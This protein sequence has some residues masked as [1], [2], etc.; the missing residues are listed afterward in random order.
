LHVD[1]AGNPN[2]VFVQRCKDGIVERTDCSRTASTCNPSGP[3]GA[4]CRGN[5][6]ACTA[7]SL[8]NDTL[9]CDGNTLVTCA[10]GQEAK[11][12]CGSILLSCF[13]NPNGT[14]FGCFA[15]NACAPDQFL[16][17]CAGTKLTFCNKGK[18]DTIDCA[19][20]G[21]KSCDPGQGGRCV[22]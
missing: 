4:H 2:G 8:T 17:T 19:S 6:Q 22:P 1:A 18:V 21:F 12:D 14:G 11:F 3:L 15:G 13:T 9:R 20:A 5:G 7:P 16:A 10:D